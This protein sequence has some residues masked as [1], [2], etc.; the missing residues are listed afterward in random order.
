MNNKI[1]ERDSFQVVG[2][3]REFSCVNGENPREIPKMWDDV[4]AMAQIT[5]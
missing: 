4:H 2:V 3:R 5:C 1:V